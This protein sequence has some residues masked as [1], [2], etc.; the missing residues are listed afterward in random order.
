MG[1]LRGQFMNTTMLIGASINLAG[2]PYTI[3][4][5]YKSLFLQILIVSPY[6]IISYGFLISGMLSSI[7]Y[8]YKIIYYSCF[9]YRKGD[10][11]ILTLYLQNNTFVSKYFVLFFNFSKYLAFILLYLF[12]VLFFIV[13]KYFVLKNYLFIYNGETVYV[14]N[15]MFLTKHTNL[16]RHLVS[17]YYILFFMTILVLLL[18]GWRSSFFAFERFSLVFSLL[19]FVYFLILF[20]VISAY[21][22]SYFF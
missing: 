18:V 6:N 15:L 12:S 16:Q 2:L 1:M 5:L 19:A 9:D 13:V 11:D 21:L 8:V 17:L 22:S 7:V 14:N 3:G 20:S 10:Q 4:Y